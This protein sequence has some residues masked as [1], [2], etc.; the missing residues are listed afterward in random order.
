MN[1]SRY[2]PVWLLCALVGF[3]GGVVV[4]VC[5]LRLA[6]GWTVAAISI[7]AMSLTV[8]VPVLMQ[9]CR[10]AQELLISQHANELQEAM[11]E[12]SNASSTMPS[13]AQ[14]LSIKP[15]CDYPEEQP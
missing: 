8:I 11:Q 10:D 6:A 14:H 4:A 1:L 3:I 12:E 15:M 2:F 9:S 13:V 7:V 5:D